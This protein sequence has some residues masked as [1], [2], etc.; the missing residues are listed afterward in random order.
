LG[1]LLA[2]RAYTANTYATDIG[3]QRVM[4]L[5]DGSIVHLNSHS[6]FRVHMSHERRQIELLEGQ[7]LFEVAHD[8]ARPFIVDSGNVSVRAVGTQFD[9]NQTRAGTVV[10]V[11]EGRVRI[12][13]VPASP[14][15]QFFLSPPAA[16]SLPG[17]SGTGRQPGGSALPE[18]GQ[19][20]P[21]PTGRARASDNTQR[22]TGAVFVAAGEQIRVAEDGHIQ[23]TE[24]PDTGAAISWLQQELRFDGEPLSDVL[25]AFNRYTKVPIVLGDPSLGSVRIN[26]VFHTTNPDSL[27]RYVAS[28]DGVEI[29]RTDKEVRIFRR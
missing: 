29:Q 14:L 13:S 26:A 22:E 27:L 25:D 7:A 4:T 11:V 10:T 3:E 8:T 2:W 15:A 20:R 16:P 23:R 6:K 12:E 9:V 21:S 28:L 5:D 17:E 19:V 18:T 1:A 24:K